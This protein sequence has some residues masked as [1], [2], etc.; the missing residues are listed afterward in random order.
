MPQNPNVVNNNNLE[1][2]SKRKTGS[3]TWAALAIALLFAFPIL[4]V[5]SAGIATKS[6]V[7]DHLVSTVLKNYLINTSILALGVGLLVAII[8]TSTAWLVT[9][10]RFPGQR[11][12]EWALILPLAVPA[13]VMAYTYTDFLQVSGPVQVLIRDIFS[14]E[15]KEYWFPEVRSIGGAILMLS[16]V[17]YP[18]VY[19]LARAA[20]LE[21]SVCALEVSRTLGCNAWESFFRVALP[22]ARPAIIA[23]TSLAL[24]ETLADFGTVSFFGV[25]TFTTGIMNAWENMGDLA[26]ARQLSTYLLLFILTV[27]VLEKV[28]RGKS[29]Y[30]HATNRYQNLPEYQLRGFKKYLALCACALPLT[31]GF[32][33][34]ALILIDMTISLGDEQFGTKFFKLAFNSFTLAAITAVIAVIIGVLLAYTNR[35]QPNVISKWATRIAAMGYAVPGTVVA[36]GTLFPLAILDNSFDAWM[37]ATFDISTGLLLTGS[38]TALV[39]AYLVRFLAVSLNTVETGLGKIRPSMEDASRTLGLGPLR[40]LWQVHIPIMSGSLMTAGLVVFVDVMK[41]LPATLVMRPFNFDTLA[42]HAYNLASDERLSES[43][44]A[45]LT[46]VLVGILP[47]ILLTRAISKSRAGSQ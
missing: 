37:R 28:S 14:I 10:C 25:Q 1:I 26:A 18:Y 23:G 24:M 44:T 20:F 30:H 35:M 47:L 6:D 12:F 2:R 33:L 15:F 11:F 45:S 40:T 16:L 3:W 32:I 17:L 43:S 34:P 5:I 4:S 41:E 46:I 7:W 8:G 9:M 27:F 22:L 13:Y 38:I 21:Q 31:L 29:K 36:I 19:M 42:V 39:F